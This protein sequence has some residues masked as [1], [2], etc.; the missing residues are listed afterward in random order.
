MWLPCVKLLKEHRQCDYVEP[1]YDESA[2]KYFHYINN[3]ELSSKKLGSSKEHS[4]IYKLEKQ[5]FWTNESSFFGENP[6]NKLVSDR[7]SN[8]LDYGHVSDDYGFALLR[9]TMEIPYVL[10]LTLGTHNPCNRRD[11]LNVPPCLSIT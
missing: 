1:N 2:E 6:L 10:I 9:M 3:F 4:F 11:L 8:N 5:N 7:G